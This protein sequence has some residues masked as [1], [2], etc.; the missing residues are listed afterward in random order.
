MLAGVAVSTFL[1]EFVQSSGSV[2]F[3][4]EG[5]S[6]GSWYLVKIAEIGCLVGAYQLLRRR[7]SGSTSTPSHYRVPL[8]VITIGCAALL[9]AAT[10]TDWSDVDTLIDVPFVPGK[11]P[12]LV[13]LLLIALLP[14]GVTIVLAARG[15]Y[16]AHVSLATIATLSALNY[17]AQ[18]G[19]NTNAYTDNGSTWAWVAVAHLLLAAV[20]WW[21]VVVRHG[22]GHGEAV[23]LR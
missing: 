22:R 8:L 23:A 19:S 14:I 2:R 9:V 3:G 7:S 1:F 15:T 10:R 5:Y 11:S 4:I 18:A 13:W 21:V 6:E 12:F 17:F 20:A 16:A